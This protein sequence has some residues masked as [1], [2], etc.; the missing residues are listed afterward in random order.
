MTGFTTK[1]K[2]ILKNERGYHLVTFYDRTASEIL[3]RKHQMR[4]SGLQTPPTSVTQDQGENRDLLLLT[5][6]C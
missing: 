3:S 5:T 1:T 2:K 6:D 4:K